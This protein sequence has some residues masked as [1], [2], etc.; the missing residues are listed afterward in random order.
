MGVLRGIWEEAI[1]LFLGSFPGGQKNEKGGGGH[2]SKKGGGDHTMGVFVFEHTRAWG[3]GI[4]NF[5]GFEDPFFRE[6]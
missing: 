4:G 1:P 2:F 6:K 3:A 5:G